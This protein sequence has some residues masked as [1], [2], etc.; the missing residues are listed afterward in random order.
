MKKLLCLLIMLLPL[1]GAAQS[2]TV[3]GTAVDSTAVVWSNASIQITLQGPNPP[4]QQGGVSVPTTYSTITNGSG[5]FSISLPSNSSLAPGDSTYAFSICG[6][7]SIPCANPFPVF[8]TGATLNISSN[9][10][11]AL[12]PATISG[13]P[14]VRAYANSELVTPQ[15]FG[16]MFFDTTLASYKYWN[17]TAWT[18]ISGGGGGAVSSV[19]GRTGAVVPAANDYNFTQLAGSATIAQLPATVVQTVGSASANTLLKWVTSNTATNTSIVDNGTSVTTTEPI[20][21]TAFTGA[22][23]GLTAFPTGQFAAPGIVSAVTSGLNMEYHFQEASGATTI[24]DYSGNSNVGTVTG[25]VGLTGTLAGGMNVCSTG[26]TPNVAPSGYVSLPLG[27]NSNVTFQVYTCT[28]GIV[29]AAITGGF[30]DQVLAGLI[31]ATAPSG[32]TTQAVGLMLAGAQGTSLA[33]NAANVAKF[34]ISPGTFNNNTVTAQSIEAVGG[35]HLI[36]LVRN[37]APT[38]D[39]IYIDGH[40]SSKY[41]F[42]GTGTL[43][44]AITST[45]ALGT[46]PYAT[47]SGTYKHPYPI[48]FAN[49]YSRALTAAEVQVNYGA[50]QKSME[51][52]GVA[53]T[54]QPASDAGQQVIAGI[55]SLTYGFTPATAGWP[56]YLTTNAGLPVTNTLYSV[57]NN[58][59]T[60]GYQIIQAIAECPTRGYSFINPNS[61]TTVILFGGT[62][63]LNGNAL[64]AT[65]L[66]AVSAAVTYQRMRRLVQCW[67]GATPQPRIFVMTMISRGGNSTGNGGV[68]NDS[69]KNAYNDLLRKDYA[70]ADGLIDIA[71][72]AIIGAD[73]A[74]LVTTGTAC[75]GGVPCFGS[76]N[77]HL[78]NGGQQNLGGLVSAYLNYADAKFNASNPTIIAATYT[79]TSA[80]VAINANPSSA[81]FTITL[82]TAVA[83]VGTERYISNYQLT[84]A[85][86][87]TI[88]P[89]TGESIGANPANTTILCANATACRFRSVLG[90]IQGG[91]NPDST[92]GAHWEQF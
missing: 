85:N 32:G 72:L 53:N 35:C 1:Y 46:A 84:G 87:V 54:F 67:K 71:S 4:Y 45:F 62:N 2:T 52:R 43:G 17:G 36:T 74:S 66:P 69:L 16:T 81:S 28:N 80:D 40:V 50:I 68:T 78:T 57:V 91:A 27:L 19:F 15:N 76:D 44:Q 79:E 51:F 24:T 38:P 9:I 7:T 20:A 90:P 75:N 14:I 37:T 22:A 92:A 5:V 21:A 8:V 89:A 47:L 26:C 6:N 88:A 70:G 63:D 48:Y 58:M 23:T 82:P 39:V 55:D 18:T 65:G 59:G 73:G 61:P 25:T 11:A 3:S 29:A 34:D 77:T 83:L 86:T 33:T 60:V 31:S 13:T 56:S 30:I 10:T 64:P 49:G 41:Q 12:T 42:T